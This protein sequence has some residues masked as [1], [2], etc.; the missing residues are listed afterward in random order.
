MFG[1]DLGISVSSV[2]C[3]AGSLIILDYAV[4]LGNKEL[5]EWDRIT[6]MSN[7]ICGT[8]RT[9]IKTN[10]SI[11]IAQMVSIEEPVYP[12]RTR[13]PRS[14]FIM[15]CLYALVRKKLQV[16]SFDI[17]SV[18]PQ[19]AKATARGAFAGKNVKAKWRSGKGHMLNK[20]GMIEA[21]R[22]IHKEEPFWSNKVG[23]E[24][25]ADS[26]FIAKT[27]LDRIKVGVK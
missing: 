9:M 10:T 15:S 11:K 23:R 7:D 24:T 2:S 17:Y 21:Y 14:F 13:N 1:I 22:R 4:L 27:G 3:V 8:I 5:N 20:D 18:N 19:S 16:R 26:F 12:Y 6:S 25:L